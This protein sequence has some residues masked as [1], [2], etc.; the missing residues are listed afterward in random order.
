M[1]QKR[2]KKMSVLVLVA[3]SIVL[4]VVGQLALKKGMNQ[5]GQISIRDLF[6]N[7]II[8]IFVNPFVDIGIFLYGVAWFLWIVILSR[9][10]LSFAYPLL[11]TGY[12]LIA[13]LSWVF[14]KEQ[15]T[16]MKMSG[17]AL[18]TIGVFMLLSKL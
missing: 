9:A 14:F 4:G 5:I 6:T 12:V 15:L 10:E 11:A 7:K 17:I 16:V 3:I 8:S 18:I 1:K 2:G 13:I